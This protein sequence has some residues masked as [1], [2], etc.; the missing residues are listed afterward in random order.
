MFELHQNSVP[1]G[2]ERANIIMFNKHHIS[3]YPPS[4][5]KTNVEILTSDMGDAN[6]YQNEQCSPSPVWFFF[7][8][9]ML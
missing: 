8:P 1:L 7:S 5:F 3:L 6:L 9:K 2:F 4:S